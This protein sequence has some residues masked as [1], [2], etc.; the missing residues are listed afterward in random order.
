MTAKD[1]PSGLVDAQVRECSVERQTGPERRTVEDRGNASQVAARRLTF[2]RSPAN[3]VGHKRIERR[4]VEVKKRQKVRSSLTIHPD[5]NERMR[6]VDGI[7]MQRTFTDTV[8]NK[9]TGRPQFEAMLVFVRGG[10][11]VIAG[12]MDR[13]ARDLEDLRQIVPELTTKGVRVQFLTEQLTFTGDDTAIPSRCHSR[14]MREPRSQTGRAD[15]ELS[16]AGV[17]LRAGVLGQPGVSA[18]V[19]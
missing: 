5:A 2:S 3:A 18:G 13:L 8:S 11:T 1:A 19:N 9:D 10:D 15:I 14:V 7:T 16:E 17:G 4:P 12:S 6:F